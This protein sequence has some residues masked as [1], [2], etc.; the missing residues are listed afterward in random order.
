MAAAT[1]LCSPVFHSAYMKLIARIGLCAA[2]S[3]CAG[4]CQH[5][6]KSF[7]GQK[8]YEAGFRAEEQGD[9]NLARQYFYQAYWNAQSSFLGPSSEAY[10]LY[11]WSR[12]TGYL[13]MHAEAEAGFT[14]VL[15]L[16]DTSAGQAEKLRAPALCELARLLHDTKQHSRA[17]PIYERA[18]SELQKL[19]A[20]QKDPIGFA[21]F[22]DDYADSLRAGGDHET[23]DAIL[24]RSA[25][26][27]ADN[28]ENLPRFN[29]RR[30]KP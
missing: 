5:P 13:G 3:L 2:I 17:L 4:G 19:G 6:G 22:L 9:L 12:V 16:I 25:A 29:P 20:P 18:L 11:E 23:A 14:N 15:T 24:K 27:K 28:K 26:I 8:C 30:Y 21:E 1:N 7:A 10:A